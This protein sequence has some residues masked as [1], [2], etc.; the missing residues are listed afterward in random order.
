MK[1]EQ[2]VLWEFIISSAFKLLGHMHI[3]H[4]K[5]R[6]ILIHIANLPKM[7]LQEASAAVFV[8]PIYT[9]LLIWCNKYGRDS[10]VILLFIFFSTYNIRLFFAR[11]VHI[12]K[13]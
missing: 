1:Q 10:Y 2:I 9:Y 6:S 8:L 3:L 12:R 5:E 13:I 4:Y 11:W 7:Y